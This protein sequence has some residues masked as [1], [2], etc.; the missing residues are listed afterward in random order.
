VSG[1]VALIIWRAGDPGPA[2]VEDALER[3]DGDD[4][5]DHGADEEIQRPPEGVYEYAGEGSERISF[6]PVSQQDGAIVP[7]TVTHGA[8]GCWEFRL[9]YNAAHWQDWLYCPSDGRIAEAGGHTHQA[10]HFGVTTVTNL[11]TFEC[12]PPAAMFPPEEPGWR[13][14]RSAPADGAMSVLTR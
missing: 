10:W 2:S 4:G 8:D 3:F 1:A 12:D 6:P 5:D 11:S 9:D 7:G 13:G 14:P